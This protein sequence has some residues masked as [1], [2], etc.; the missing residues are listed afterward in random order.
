MRRSGVGE[1]GVWQRA[2][3]SLRRGRR[4][5]T[6]ALLAA[7]TALAVGVAACGGSD[8]SAYSEQA[9]EALAPA[10]EV[11][12]RA[13]EESQIAY[14][15]R[16]RVRSLASS[17]MA[18]RALGEARTRLAAIDVP[19]DAAADHQRLQTMTNQTLRQ[20]RVR[21]DAYARDE[22]GDA[23]IAEMRIITALNGTAARVDPALCETLLS[24]DE[25]DACQVHGDPG[26]YE[27]QLSDLFRGFAAGF[28]PRVGGVPLAG[29]DDEVVAYLEV[30]QPE[31]TELLGTTR[32]DLAELQPPVDLAD[33][34]R[35]LLGY[36]A[37]T[38][39][40][41]RQITRAAQ[42][43]DAER[44]R[45]LFAKSGEP[46]QQTGQDLS[47]RGQEIV[48]FFFASG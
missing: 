29:T 32:A 31:V 14:R 35:L 1:R 21:R 28:G 3:K 38:E 20:A 36:L 6:L 46:F 7:A 33:D 16:A 26:T 13:I 47:E 30:I 12:D 37:S 44:L 43:G 40:I 41:A 39:V 25:R 42:A 19:A 45:E 11:R 23:A 34:H 18:V 24:A 17:D 2:W 48:G 8:G 10:L 15:D 5:R 27:R 4:G 9:S 22:V